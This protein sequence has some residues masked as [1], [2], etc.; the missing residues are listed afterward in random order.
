MRVLVCGGRDYAN[1]MRVRS[2]MNVLHAETT[3]K[4]V[5]HGNCGKV[6]PETLIVV[7]GADLMAKEWA[8][9]HGVTQVPYP[10][11]W[12][13]HGKAAGPIR[14]QTMLDVG[15]PDLVVAFPGGRGTDDM[16][17]KARAAGVQVMEVEND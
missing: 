9:D 16:V 3:I 7:R 17:A 2:V 15:K 13:T 4:C 5:I 10:A 12:D 8:I 11:D 14:N 1:K 6:D